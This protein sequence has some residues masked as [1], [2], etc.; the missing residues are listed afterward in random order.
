MDRP[1]SSASTCRAGSIEATRGD[2]RADLREAQGHLPDRHHKLDADDGKL[3][4]HQ[5]DS[6]V[7]SRLRFDRAETS[8]HEAAAVLDLFGRPI[9]LSH[10]ELSN[11]NFL[12]QPVLSDPMNK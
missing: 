10:S 11:L 1:A 3:D 8:I 6:R 7:R 12:H 9:A 4:P 5:V 2:M